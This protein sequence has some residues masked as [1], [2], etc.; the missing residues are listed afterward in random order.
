M[1]YENNLLFL[2]YLFFN[3]LAFI[4][5]KIDKN[6]AISNKWRIS[7]NKLILCGIIG[8]FG[9]YTGMQVFHHKTRKAKFKILIPLFLI[10][11]VFFIFYYLKTI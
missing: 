7:E 6:N 3:I 9:A 4:I 1:I 5:Y 8:P 10:I 2:F 11:H